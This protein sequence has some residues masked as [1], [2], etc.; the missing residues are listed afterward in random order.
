[1]DGNVYGCID[2]FQ[3]YEYSVCTSGT[4]CR[5]P[6]ANGAACVPTPC[7]PGTIGCASEKLGQCADDGMSVTATADCG[8]QGQVCTLAGCAASALDEI[9]T[10][11]QVG[12]ASG[13]ELIGNVF[14]V[15]SARKLT[16]IEYD[17]SLPLQRSLTW[18]IYE[19][20]NADL[21][22]EFELEYKKVTIASGTGLQSSGVVDFELGA[23]KTYIIGVTATDGSFGYYYDN[24][25]VPPSINFAHVIATVDVAYAQS[26]DFQNPG[27][28][29]TYHQRLTT[30]AP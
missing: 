19:Q 6:G 4:Y 2:G 8:A 15:E 16:A 20:T 27:L 29:A 10:S 25:I 13:G 22:G 26:F 17:L 14:F 28:Y 23:G 7:A 1:M 30:T 11:T 3:Y 5:D 24:L 12:S 9:A 21:N 18:A